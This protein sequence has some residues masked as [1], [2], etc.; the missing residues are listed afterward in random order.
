MAGSAWRW[1]SSSARRRS[2]R[3]CASRLAL[4]A[5]LTFSGTHFAFHATHLQHYSHGDAVGQT[6]ALAVG[7][8]LPA[9][10]LLLT[11]AKSG[12]RESAPRDAQ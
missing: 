8:V 10:L 11:R 12:S 7:V 9:T 5:Y 2:L 4:V 6:L 3:T 1:P